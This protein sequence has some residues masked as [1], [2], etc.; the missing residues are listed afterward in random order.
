MTQVYSHFHYP[1]TA[2]PPYPFYPY[3]STLLQLILRHVK[4]NI[5]FFLLSPHV[6]VLNCTYIQIDILFL[7]LF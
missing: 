3:P 5:Y 2:R 7:K 4:K 1:I 6:S